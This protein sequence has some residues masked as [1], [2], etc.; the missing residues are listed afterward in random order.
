VTLHLFV[1]IATAGA[2]EAYWHTDTAE[3]LL[4]M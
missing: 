4:M 2:S 3:F 1:Y